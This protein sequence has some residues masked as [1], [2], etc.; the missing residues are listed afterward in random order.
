MV[1][2][3]TSVALVGLVALDFSALIVTICVLFGRYGGLG[4]PVKQSHCMY[5]LHM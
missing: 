3:I 2:I 4:Q 1:L 5:L